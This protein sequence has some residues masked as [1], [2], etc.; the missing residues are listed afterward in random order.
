[1]DS[2]REGLRDL[3]RRQ[4]LSN[5]TWDE[6]CA[7][8]SRE[9]KMTHQAQKLLDGAEDQ[10]RIAVRHLEAAVEQIAKALRQ[11]APIPQP[12]V[13]PARITIEKPYGVPKS[14]AEQAKLDPYPYKLEYDK[15][16]GAVMVKLP[17][18]VPGK[19][20]TFPAE[21]GPI[22]PA[23]AD[24]QGWQCTYAAIPANTQEGG[25]Y[26]PH[27]VDPAESSAF[28]FVDAADVSPLYKKSAEAGKIRVAKS[29]EADSH[30]HWGQLDI[31]TSELL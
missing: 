5:G 30:V 7:A 31:R 26:G 10:R 28:R 14:Y 3:I 2:T 22:D 19:S 25:H 13:E 29:K 4:M 18:E 16:S 6:Y 1:M 12:D 8:R 15:S 17:D 20:L 9:E 23:P 27:F 21:G 24:E 11:E